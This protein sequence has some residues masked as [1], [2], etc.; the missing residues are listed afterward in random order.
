MTT[1][2]DPLQ[3]IVRLLVD[4][5][6]LLH[7]LRRGAEPAPAATLIGRLRALIPPSVR[8][9]IVFDGPPDPGSSNVRVASGVTVRYSGRMSADAL[10]ARLV[11]EAA[12]HTIETAATILVVT[13]DH[14]LARELRRRGATT[15]RTAWLL[16]RLER[17]SLASPSVGRAR[18]PRQRAGGDDQSDRRGE[19]E[20]PEESE[21]GG[22]RPGRGATTKRGNPHR[23]ARHAPPAAGR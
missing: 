1:A 6:N 15:A 17:A 23:R 11:S 18:P 7:A 4:G 10:L 16:H 12:A 22:W 21:G 3:G 8:I 13:D 9:E 14:E 2:R 20:A 5:T 19:G